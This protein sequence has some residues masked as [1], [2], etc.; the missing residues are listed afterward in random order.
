MSDIL[1]GTDDGIFR[2][3]EGSKDVQPETGPSAIAFLAST[4]TGVF[5]LARDGAFTN[6][7]GVP[8]SAL[9][10]RNGKNDWQLVN[11]HPVDE[12]VWSFA[13]DSRMEGRLYLGV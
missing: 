9:W 8:K 4:Q 7:A 13:G 6:T 11:N 12:E 5:A 1:I 10:L 2:L 3:D